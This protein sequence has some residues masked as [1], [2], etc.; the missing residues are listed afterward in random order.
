MHRASTLKARQLR[1]VSTPYERVLWKL[2]RDR[3]LDDFKFRRQHPIGRYV[4]D[5]ASVAA[6]LVVELDGRIHDEQQDYD[7]VRDQFLGDNGWKVLRFSNRDL[8]GHPEGVWLAIEAQLATPIG[9][10]N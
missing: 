5:F 6:M 10:E 3:Q 9:N 2:L 8:T 7:A 4:A 1:R